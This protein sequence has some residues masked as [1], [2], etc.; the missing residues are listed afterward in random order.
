MHIERAGDELGAHRT[1]IRERDPIRVPAFDNNAI[2]PDLRLVA[3]ARRNK[4]LHQAARQI[5]RATLAELVTA[6]EIEGADHRAHRARLRQRVDK[7]S[8]EQRDLEQEQQ[9]HVLVLKE[10]LYHIEWLAFASRSVCGS[11]SE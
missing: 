3:A 7:P 2:D 4:S 6:F 8:A 9:L 1:A 10:L 5:E 11:G